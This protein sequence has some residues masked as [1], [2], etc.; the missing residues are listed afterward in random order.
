MGNRIEES[1]KYLADFL[2]THLFGPSGPHQALK[3]FLVP[4]DHIGN[5][6]KHFLPEGYQGRV[7][8]I[9]AKEA[10]TLPLSQ[11]TPANLLLGIGCLR[12][13]DMDANGEG[14]HTPQCTLSPP[15]GQLLINGSLQLDR[16][17]PIG[18]EIM[19]TIAGALGGEFEMI[20]N[21]VKEDQVDTAMDARVTR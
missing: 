6:L 4:R 7:C 12:M 11:D 20:R 3:P 9:S 19:Y 13:F 5:I 17:G 8:P 14:G 1:A 2:N 10:N 16:Y 15:R 21:V 18:I